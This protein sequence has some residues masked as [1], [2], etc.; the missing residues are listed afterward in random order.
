LLSGPVPQKK[1]DPV[2]NANLVVDGA[3]IVPDNRYTDPEFGRD[4]SVLHS[5]RDQF[6]DSSFASAELPYADQRPLLDR[7]FSPRW[8]DRKGEPV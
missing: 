1:F 5:M 7:Q 6:Y 4:F 8:N 3:Q 2:A